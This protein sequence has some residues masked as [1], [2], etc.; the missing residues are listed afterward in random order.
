MT[1]QFLS[2]FKQINTMSN[3]LLKKI[4]RSHVPIYLENSNYLVDHYLAYTSL[5][6]PHSLSP[7]PKDM[8]LSSNILF[9]GTPPITTD[10]R[11]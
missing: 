6:F 2:D 4:S 10:F 11:K 7:C 5:L 9:P 1:H 3:Y 8:F